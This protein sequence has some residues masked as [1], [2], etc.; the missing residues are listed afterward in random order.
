MAID[1]ESLEVLNLIHYGVPDKIIEEHA[2]K[3]NEIYEVLGNLVEDTAE[4]E[5]ENMEINIGDLCTHCGRDTS[6][7]S[8]ELLFV[9][10]IPSGTDGTLILAG[11]DEVKVEVEVTGYMCADC[12]GVECDE[13]GNKVLDYS[14]RELKIKC[15]D[16]YDVWDKEYH[17]DFCDEMCSDYP[18]G[19]EK[20]VNV[21]E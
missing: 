12:Q 18:C 8:G 16:C 15:S 3:I 2:E 1:K 21:A 14:I 13:C 11:G 19:E 6:L 7:E 10:R 4:P 20:E 5:M 9:N 17:P